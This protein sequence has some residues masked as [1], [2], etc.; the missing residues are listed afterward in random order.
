MS[1]G[2]QQKIS[3]NIQNRKILWVGKNLV[4]EFFHSFSKQLKALC[5]GISI[6]IVC[7]CLI[8]GDMLHSSN[9]KDAALR[10]IVRNFD[11][12]KLVGNVLN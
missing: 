8:L 1:V 11:D 7:Q 10:F 9:L 3:E 2:C 4:R 12:V 6:E 5:K